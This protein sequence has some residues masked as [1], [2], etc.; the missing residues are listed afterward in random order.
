MSAPDRLLEVDDLEVQFFTRRGVV[1]AVRGTSF[2]VDRGETL[3]LVGE[4]GSGKSVTSL[5]VLGLIQLPGKITGG[6]VRWKGQSLLDSAGRRRI[7]KI[8]GKELA[9]V[10]QDPMTSLNPLFTVGAQIREVLCHHLDLRRRQA[11][12]RVVELL[13]L[14]GIPSPR[15]RTKAY[16][17]ELSGGQRQRVMIAMALACEPELL[18]ADEPTTALD[19]TIQAQILELIAEIQQRLG[20]AV[21]LVTHDLGVVA[22]VCDRVVVMYGGRIMERGA[23]GEVFEHP[24]HPYTAG[25]L[26]STPRL[27][28]VQRRLVGIDGTPPNMIEP[29]P[30]CPFTPRCPVMTEQCGEQPPFVPSET[31]REVACWRAYDTDTVWTGQEQAELRR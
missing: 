6:D 19:V 5:A 1:Q 27:D 12:E 29:P 15:E 8:R 21:L 26:R 11:D 2:H 20:L 23:A 10:F 22:G 17:H 9:V 7:R 4:S 24:G 13:D 3:G 16:P 28:V 18:I 14:V 30:G 25:L 31:G